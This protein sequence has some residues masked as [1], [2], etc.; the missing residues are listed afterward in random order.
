VTDISRLIFP[1]RREKN[2]AI[3]ISSLIK[4]RIVMVNW[5]LR[6]QTKDKQEMYPKLQAKAV[7]RELLLL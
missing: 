1:K 2:L 3:W 4:K 5:K 6:M 7:F